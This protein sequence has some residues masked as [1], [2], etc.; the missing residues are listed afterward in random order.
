MRKKLQEAARP[1]T[2]QKKLQF[3]HQSLSFIEFLEKSRQQNSKFRQKVLT[4]IPA[5][6]SNHADQ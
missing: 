1:S 5:T 6:T 2:P 4:E 3:E